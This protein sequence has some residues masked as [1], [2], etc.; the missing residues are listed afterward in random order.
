MRS[1]I[2]I[3]LRGYVRL[4]VGP[5]VGRSVRPSVRPSVT[6][7]LK[8]FKSAIFD[9]KYY[10]YER[11][12]ISCRVSGLVLKNPDDKFQTL[13]T[14]S[15]FECTTATIAFGAF[16]PSAFVLTHLDTRCD[17]TPS[18]FAYRFEWERISRNLDLCQSISSRFNSL[19]EFYRSARHDTVGRSFFS[20]LFSSLSSSVLYF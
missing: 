13:C 14:V 11:E 1:R 8:P 7:E 18:C 20:S 15:C 4:S 9:Q 3:R 16:V 12:R 19:L 6:H 10:Q 2:S 5:S 17:T